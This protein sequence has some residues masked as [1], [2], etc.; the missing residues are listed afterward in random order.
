MPLAE[1][2]LVFE[3]DEGQPEP[4]A[5]EMLSML[6]RECAVPGVV[7]NACQSALLGEQVEDPFASVAAALLR[8]GMRSVVAMAYSL[9]VSGAQQFLPAFYGRLFEEGRVAPAVR[10]GRQQMLSHPD[11]V[12][13]RGLFPLQDWL[14]PVLYEQD[15]LDFSFARAASEGFTPKPSKLPDALQREQNPYGFIGR[16]GPLLELERALRRPPSGVLISGLGGVGKTTLARGFLQWLDSTGGLGEGCF[17]FGFQEIRSAEFV[18][19][20]I[21]ETLLG[22]QFA[23]TRSYKL[24]ALAETLCAK[25]FIIVWDNFESAAGIPGTAVNA[26][27][28]EADR[29]LLAEFLDKLRGGASKVLITSRSTEDWLGA[30]RRFLLPLGGLAGEERWEYCEVILKDMGLH[31]NRN[32]KDLVELMKLLGGHPLAMRAILPRL[33]RLSAA[34]VVKALRSN[35]ADL[36]LGNETE[37]I[38]FAAMRFVEQG[39]PQDLRPLLFPVAMHEG[40]LDADFIESMAQQEGGGWTRS[41]IDALMN[42]LVVAGLLRDVGQATYEMHPVLTVYLRSTRFPTT[43]A[44]ARDRWARAFVDIMSRFANHLVLLC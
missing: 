1:G 29:T 27:L 30:G 22:S 36:K 44:E 9:Y 17:W 28:P 5:A 18:F 31:I 14:V 33:E 7:L 15:P 35:I 21:G 2:Q 34:E 38:L 4:V 37:Q 12:C 25:R 13:V 42:A 39:L 32:D 11:R 40:F 41:D 20:R 16:D 10:A 23:A 6:L 26:N 3:T 19:N 24:E 8:S 43:Q